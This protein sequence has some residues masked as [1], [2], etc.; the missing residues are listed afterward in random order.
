MKEAFR[1]LT[2]DHILQ[3][4]LSDWDFRSSNEG[5]AVGYNLYVFD[6][7]YQEN[8]TAAQPSKVEF[9]IDGVVQSFLNGFT[10]VLTKRL[11]FIISDEQRHFALF[12]I[13]F[14]FD[15]IPNKVFQVIEKFN[16]TTFWIWF[17]KKILW[18]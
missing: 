6:I 5:N 9:K 3:T 12:Q 14:S 18:M 10:F 7:W 1:T 4:Y 13:E 16:S 8:F 17:S 2:K 15:Y 11:V